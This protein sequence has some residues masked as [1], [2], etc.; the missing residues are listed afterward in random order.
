MK[1]LSHFIPGRAAPL[2]AAFAW[3]M[4]GVAQ[5]ASAE[6]FDCVINPSQRLRIG[7]PVTTTLRS[8]AVDRGDKVTKGQILAR[9]ESGVEEA[10]VALNEARAG[11]IADVTS[12][13]ARAE[14][15]RLE[16]DRGEAL[17][18]DNNAPRQKVEEART[19]L[20]VAQE[21][22]QIAMLN[23]RVAELELARSKTLLEQRTIR[24]PI[25]GVVVQRLLGPGEYVHQDSPIIEMAAIDP[26]Y[27]E[28][29][30][31]VRFYGEI[32]AGMSASVRPDLPNAHPYTAIVTVV[33]QVF[34]A[35]SGTFGVRLALPN[36]GGVL[37]AGLRCH[38]VMKIPAVTEVSKP[39]Q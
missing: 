30:P 35:G 8:V 4:L 19:Q 20:R 28:A 6:T 24:A 16:A 10:D 1:R 26:L 9:L 3:L 21:D 25:D 32:V 37:S 34:D 2:A 5:S 11:N 38:V 13:A 15:A 22:L 18:K 36:P 17:L 23:H 31:S 39:D 27:V 29:Y 12:R 7:S 14:F 33:D